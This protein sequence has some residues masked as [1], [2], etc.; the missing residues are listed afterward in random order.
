M[1]P[2]RIDKYHVKHYSNE[3]LG[4][5]DVEVPNCCVFFPDDHLVRVR[6]NFH[7]RDLPE[8]E[9][10]HIGVMLPPTELNATYQIIVD[11]NG[12]LSYVHGSK[13]IHV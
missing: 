11:D 7:W 4:V 12:C 1:T 3:L 13:L 8:T 2:E 9:G 6:T 10:W 5:P